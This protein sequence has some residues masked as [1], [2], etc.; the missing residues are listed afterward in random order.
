MIISKLKKFESYLS[1]LNF[2]HWQY[3]FINFFS[4]KIGK[5]KMI[6]S[7]FLSF[8]ENT[9]HTTSGLLYLNFF[10]IQNAW[11]RT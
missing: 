2:K 7:P 10:L 5:S 11:M 9:E 3:T 8:V 6:Q 4:K 1:F